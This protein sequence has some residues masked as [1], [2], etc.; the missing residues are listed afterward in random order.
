MASPHTLW[1]LPFFEKICKLNWPCAKSLEHLFFIALVRGNNILQN[2]EKNTFLVSKLSY[3][4]TCCFSVARKFFF[5]RHLWTTGK[6]MSFHLFH[7]F[8]RAEFMY[9]GEGIFLLLVDKVQVWNIYIEKCPH[10]RTTVQYAPHPTYRSKSQAKNHSPLWMV[11]ERF[12]R[13]WGRN[14]SS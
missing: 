5:S 14:F 4:S 12:F 2:T 1:G 11:P 3:W 7:A 8:C 13:F 10:L 6:D 9:G